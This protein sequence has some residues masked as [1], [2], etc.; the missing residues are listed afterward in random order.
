MFYFVEVTAEAR[1]GCETDARREKLRS[2]RPKVPEQDQI[3]KLNTKL[4]SK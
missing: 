3:P 4:D 1:Q 2:P